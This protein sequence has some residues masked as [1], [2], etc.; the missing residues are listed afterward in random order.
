MLFIEHEEINITLL[1][2]DSA[3]HRITFY[4]ESQ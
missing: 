1:T 2:L 3:M 4:K